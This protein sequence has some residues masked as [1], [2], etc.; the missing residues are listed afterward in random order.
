MAK[1]ERKTSVQS[2]KQSKKDYSDK[3]R[4][5]RFLFIYTPI[6]I[7]TLSFIYAFSFDPMK[8]A[9]RIQIE[10]VIL[11]VVEPSGGVAQD[12]YKVRFSNG[13]IVTISSDEKKG[14]SKGTR[15][16]VEENETLI[17]KR[18]VYQFIRFVD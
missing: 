8:P 15:V 5:H 13:N 3:K 1:R 11:E 7:I 18:K 12:T 6:I 2:K 14:V 17:F 4:L 16:L 10:G 9:S